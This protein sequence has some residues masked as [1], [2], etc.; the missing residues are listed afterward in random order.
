MKEERKK[1]KEKGKREEIRETGSIKMHRTSLVIQCLR[2]CMP[3]KGTWVQSL[4]QEDST[5]WGN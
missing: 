4:V 5:S 3:V 1:E 2:I